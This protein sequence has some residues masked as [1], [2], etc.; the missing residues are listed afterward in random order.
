MTGPR[1]DRDADPS[2]TAPTSREG[3]P[4]DRDGQD[5]RT[6]GAR[7]DDRAKDDP[8]RAPESGTP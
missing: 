2:R 1:N 6:A 8:S 4:R 7:D 5:L 3:D